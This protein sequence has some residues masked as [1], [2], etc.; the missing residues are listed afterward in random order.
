MARLSVMFIGFILSLFVLMKG[1]PRST[2][3]DTS[4]KATFAGGCFWCMQP[5][6]EGLK[7]VSSVIVGYT[8]GSGQGPTYEDYAAKGHVEAIEITYDPSRISYEALLD[9]FWRQID[10]T[11]PGGQFCDR[12][13]QYRSAIFYHD[14]EQARLAAASKATLANSGRYKKPLVTEILKASTFFPAEDYHQDYH[15]KNPIRYKFY[16]WNCGG[17][18]YLKEIWGSDVNKTDAPRDPTAFVKPSKEELKKTLKPMQYKVT[19][20]EGTEPAFRNELWNNERAGIYVD[21]VSGEP[22]FSSTDK[23]DSGTGWPSFTRPLEPK[24]IVERKDRRLN[25]TRIEVRSAH[26]DSHL[27][28]VF[29][30]GPPPTGLRYCMNSAALRFIPK[31]DLEKE[32]YGEYLKLFK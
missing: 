8:G 13:P 15:K 24:N 1:A 4:N 18:R 20:E 31:E 3:P 29:N 26:A 27:G 30:D 17:D 11:D 16:R 5:P 23:Y 19:Q 7:G 28:H 10:P 2:G 14:D 32:G 6:F 12:G 9:V 22:L 21:I 25:T